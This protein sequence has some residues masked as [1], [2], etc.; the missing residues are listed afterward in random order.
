MSQY[1]CYTC[2]HHLNKKLECGCTY[3]CSKCNQ[4]VDNLD[5][6]CNCEQRNE[7]DDDSDESELED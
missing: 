2:G 6:G 5:E 3:L 7:D 4:F 1:F